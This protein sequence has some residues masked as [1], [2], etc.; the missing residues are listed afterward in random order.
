MILV[1]SG[2][3]TRQAYLHTKDRMSIFVQDKCN[4][5]ADECN[6]CLAAFSGIEGAKML[7]CQVLYHFHQ[8]L[9]IMGDACNECIWA[10]LIYHGASCTQ[11]G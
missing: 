5:F 6:N 11:S 8:L 9:L 2:V 3:S 7:S 10:V 1:D 4:E